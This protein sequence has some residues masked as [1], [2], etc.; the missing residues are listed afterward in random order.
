MEKLKIYFCDFWP[1][2]TYENI[3]LPILQK[4][5]DVEI[6]PNNPDVVIHSIFGGVK[7]SANYKCKKIVFI[8]ENYRAH[9]YGADYSISFDPHSKTNYRLPLWQF[10]LILNPNYKSIL[11]GPRINHEKFD[12]GGAFVVSNSA[13][14]FRNGFYNKFHLDSWIQWFSYG[15]YLTNNFDLIKESQGRYWRDAKFDF[16]SKHKHQYMITFENN[17]YPYYCTEKLM[18]AFLVGSMPLY[19]GDPRVNEDWNKDA[20]INVGKMGQDAA[21]DLLKDMNKDNNLFK[22]MYEQPIFTDEQKQR[23][24]DNINHFQNWLIEIIKK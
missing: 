22:N 17:S 7:Q 9:N 1:E 11:F 5:F 10:Y 4:Y 6:T 15:R 8:G 12:R 21:Y 24:I 18:D 16:F 20:F 13:N 14:F 3:F 2:I 19:W 23:H